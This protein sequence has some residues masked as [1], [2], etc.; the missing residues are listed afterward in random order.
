MPAL[1]DVTNAF[2][3]RNMFLQVALGSISYL[4][5]F[6]ALLGRYGASSNGRGDT[7]DEALA[8]VR[9]ADDDDCLMAILGVIALSERLMAQ[10]PALRARAQRLTG[11][12]DG[13][14]DDPPLAV[15][16]LLE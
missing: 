5:R 1:H 7:V 14:T 15:T 16:Q 10:R 11:T 2:D 4:R 8:G 9:P 3:D 13:A 12:L 6:H